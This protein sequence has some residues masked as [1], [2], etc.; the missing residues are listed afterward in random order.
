[1]SLLTEPANIQVLVVGGSMAMVLSF[2]PFQ[3]LTMPS[4]R[5]YTYYLSP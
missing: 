1:M 2:R 4:K 3:S 5:W